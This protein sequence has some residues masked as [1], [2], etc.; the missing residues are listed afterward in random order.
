M[1]GLLTRKKS[2]TAPLQPR[3][4]QATASARHLA[5]MPQQTVGP[6]AC[7]QCLQTLLGLISEL[8][9]VKETD[10]PTS[11]VSREPFYPL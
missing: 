5:R 9:P 7:L 3:Q 8:V 11:K 2:L 1:I 10:I 6:D 4:P